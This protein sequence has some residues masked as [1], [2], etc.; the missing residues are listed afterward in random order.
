MNYFKSLFLLC[1]FLWAQ[2]S[3]AQKSK[4][5]LVI[6]LADQHSYDELGCYGNTQVKTP[7]IDKFAKEGIRFNQCFSNEPICTP[8]R[9]L[10]MSGQH[11]LKNGCYTNDVPLIPGNGKK[12]AE[13]LR[14]NGYNTAYIGKWHLLG[15]DRNRPIPR[16]EMRYGFDETFLTDNCTTQFEAGKAYYWDDNDEKVIFNKWQPYGQTDQAL[17][18]LDSRKNVDKPFVMVVAWHPPH[19]VGKEI[20]LDGKKHYTY[21]APE[22][23]MALY[24][25]DMI[26]VRPGIKSTPDLRRMYQGHYAMITGIDKAFGAIMDK[27]KA[28]NLDENTIVVYSA[29]HGD[30]LEHFDINEPKQHPQDYSSRIPFLMRWP[31]HLKAGTSTNLLFGAMDM[32]PTLLGLMNMPVPKECDGKNLSKAILTGNPKAVDYVPY[33][34][35]PERTRGVFTQ[36]Y[37]F[38][39]EKNG[40][41]KS[42]NNV[43]YDRKNDPY[44]LTNLFGDIRY[45]TIQADLLKLTYSAM[46]KYGDNFYNM[47]QAKLI[48]EKIKAQNPENP[49]LKPDL[50]PRKPSE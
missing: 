20:G 38:S 18:Y 25:P 15:G 34:C 10:L 6:L 5:N 13:V 24:N 4:P 41:Q 14:D 40:T 8:F 43:L 39:T 36:N 9:G 11:S 32:M 19:N 45:K 28:L 44:Q 1:V 37:T 47:Q 23:L 31:K 21:K 46:K 16:G 2:L 12:L 7:N 48:T 30:L 49:Y 3:F 26:K 29:D 50:R 22:E 35:F 33:W 42:V 17:E 27:L